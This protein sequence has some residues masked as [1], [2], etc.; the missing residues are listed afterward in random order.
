MPLQANPMRTELIKAYV[1]HARNFTDSRVLVELFSAEYGRM[2]VV[3][4]SSKK[5]GRFRVLRPFQPLLVSWQGK[6]DL[7][8]L[9]H[10]ESGGQ[11]LSIVGDS[12]YCGMYLNELLL[13]VIATGDPHEN[14]FL[15]YQNAITQLATSAAIEPVLRNFELDL[16][17][18]LGYGI[19]FDVDAQT[20]EPIAPDA[21]YTFAAADGFVLHLPS[22]GARNVFSGDVIQTVGRREFTEP[23][24]RS[25]AKQI[26]RLALEP[27]L[28]GKPLKSREL[29]VKGN[30]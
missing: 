9:T 7:K 18:E 20:G 22:Q 19:P 30:F 5:G 15:T 10:S 29:F 3:A 2:G 8:T 26:C 14:L 11:P 16:L 28:G 27:L 21:H 23:A 24:V 6:S 13:R 17:G 1:L 4:R 25:A 12:L